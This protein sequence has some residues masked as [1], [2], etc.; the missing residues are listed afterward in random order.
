M[1]LK[2][3]FRD[4]TRKVPNE[5]K[6]K[7]CSWFPRTWFGF[8]QKDRKN[9]TCG[10][11]LRH[12][13]RNTIAMHH[14][15]KTFTPPLVPNVCLQ[16]FSLFPLPTPFDQRPVHRHYSCP[17]S[18]YCRSIVFLQLCSSLKYTDSWWR[19]S[20][21]FHTIGEINTGNARFH[22]PF[23]FDFINTQLWSKHSQFR[24]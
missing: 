22:A 24:E 18:V 12:L 11:K 13:V 14:G 9:T 15:G 7:L 5:L 19:F 17:R 20:H 23:Q 6:I 2:G 10:G 21:I 1:T 16:A 8:T 3:R 4:A